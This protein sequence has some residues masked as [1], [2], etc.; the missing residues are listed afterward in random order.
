MFHFKNILPKFKRPDLS[1]LK[2]RV[3]HPNIHLPDPSEKISAFSRFLKRLCRLLVYMLALAVLVTAVGVGSIFYFVTP[4]RV[5][6]TLESTAKAWFDATVA[7]EGDLLLTR[8]P[9]L[10]VTLPKTT[11]KR[12]DAVLARFEEA[13]FELS[14]WALPL[15]AIRVTDARIN[16][17]ETSVTLPKLSTRSFF[18]T[19]LS[20]GTFPKPL[21]I[22]DFSLTNASC[23]LTVEETKETCEM[24]DIALTLH[25]LSPD[26]E[27]PFEMQMKFR[28]PK[29]AEGVE[30]R[31]GSMS[32]TGTLSLKTEKKRLL[33]DDLRLSGNLGETGELGSLIASVDHVRIEP[34]EII[35]TNTQATLSNPQQADRSLAFAAIDTRLIPTGFTSPEMRLDLA[36]AVSSNALKLQAKSAVDY[37]YATGALT[38]ENL[39]TSITLTSNAAPES[40][41]SATLSGFLRADCPKQTIDLGLAGDIGKDP[42]T[43]RGTLALSQK[44]TLTGDLMLASFDVSKLAMLSD[45]DW[46]SRFDFSGDLRIGQF[47]IG[48]VPATQLHGKLQLKEGKTDLTDTILNIAEGRLIGEGHLA[49]DASWSAKA[50]VDSVNLEKLFSVLAPKSPFGGLASGEA[51]VTGQGLSAENVHATADLRLLRNVL[52]GID[53]ETVHARIVDANLK[54]PPERPD[55]KVRFDEGQAKCALEGRKLRI[56]P[57]SVRNASMQTAGE[58]A[59]ELSKGEMEGKFET[60]FAPTRAQPAVGIASTLTGK[61]DAPIWNFDYATAQA[62]LKRAY[63]PK[64]APSDKQSIWKRIRKLFRF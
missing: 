10:S 12:G 6:A 49:A 33:F 59:F 42:L 31:V 22:L 45:S 35:A 29:A 8:F 44:P 63:G 38:L 17:L 13:R 15:G 32:A 51:T 56:S 34:S 57:V 50:Q 54:T 26:M 24:R 28:F 7:V 30:E 14:H 36:D 37:T 20:A 27:T 16:R 48:S 64:G 9:V 23:D 5:N 4:A 40:P 58:L 21:R 3:P 41:L 61:L 60:A 52:R 18:E 25:Q 53:F 11:L 39:R 43:F 1:G 2:A 46:L 19:L 55:A 62:A 47:H